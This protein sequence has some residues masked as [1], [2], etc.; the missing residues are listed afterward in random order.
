MSRRIRMTYM[1]GRAATQATV[2]LFATA[3]ALPPAQ[4]A[5]S[6][7]APPSGETV[8]LP[9]TGPAYREADQAYRA[10]ARANY[11][12]AARHAREALRLRP[13]V[14]RLHTLLGDALAAAQR[15]ARMAGDA[16]A[17]ARAPSATVAAPHASTDSRLARRAAA[18]AT[19]TASAT[20]PRVTTTVAAQ[21]PDY[22]PP[23]RVVGDTMPMR[24]SLTLSTPSVQALMQH[25]GYALGNRPEAMVNATAA[26]TGEPLQAPAPPPPAPA[27]RAYVAMREGHP[28]EAAAAFA[29]ADRQGRLEPRQLQDAA[30]ASLD[31]GDAPAAAGY[32]R[33]ALDAADDGRIALTP[34]QA[35]DVRVAVAD[36]ERNW[37]A[38]VAGFYRAGGTVPGLAP[39]D[40]GRD[41]RSLQ[42]VSEVYWRPP[43]LKGFA[44][45]GTFVDVYGRLLGTL[46]SGAGYA[47]G[48]SSAQ[49]AFGVR[50]K[51][52]GPVNLVGAAERLVKVGSA[53]RDDWLLRLG[54]SDSFNTAPRVGRGS[55]WTGD[56]Y[57]ETGRYLQAGEKYVTSEARLGRS[58][59]V[60]PEGGWNGV[61]SAVLTPHLVLAADYNTGYTQPRAVGAGVGMSLRTWLREDSRSGPRSYMDLSL[62]LRHRLSGDSR[63]GGVVLRLSY[64]H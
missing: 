29:E 22:G 36:Q 38:S 2:A 25:T 43:A 55:W 35:Q 34:Q 33:R 50:A 7:D 4:A 45:G 23:D 52:F 18:R 44:G 21:A 19:R 9:L 24:L 16:P 49:A 58:W 5:P 10:Y 37:G 14:Q 61:S 6:A 12:E 62:Q 63:A 3:L 27:E 32:F 11:A 8:E 26:A 41:D 42:A 56:V 48:G 20:A 59:R 60:D 46:Y 15:Q 39:Q 13:D 53:S 54:F 28:R 17:V 1:A 40:G 30:F 57:A 64:N 31:A 47:E 51:P